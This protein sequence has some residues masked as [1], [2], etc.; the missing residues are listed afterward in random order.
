MIVFFAVFCF[1]FKKF[2]IIV[3]TAT[4]KMEAAR[5]KAIR[6]RAWRHI[7]MISSNADN[8]AIKS[9]V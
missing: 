2:Q 3:R 1:D 4:D 7:D 5:L 8:T 6:E 9:Q